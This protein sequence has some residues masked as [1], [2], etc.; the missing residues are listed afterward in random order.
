M[1]NDSGLLNSNIEIVLNKWKSDFE[2][3]YNRPADLCGFD[4]DFYNQAKQM[5][6]QRE[7]EMTAGDYEMNQEINIDIS[8]DEVE[9][10]I[11][12][13]KYKKAV[14]FDGIPNEALKQPEVVRLLYI[15]FNKCFNLFTLPTIWLKAVISPIPKSSS[16]DPNIPLSYTGISLLSCSCKVYSGI[17]NNRIV[18]YFALLELFAD[19]QNGFRKHRSCIDHIF[20][21][22][23]IIRNRIDQGLSTFCCFIDMKKAFDWVDRD[24]LF[25]KLLMYNIDGKIYNSIK[26]LYSHPLSSIKLNNYRTDWF[27][28]ESGVRQGDSLSPT[29]FGIF[30]YNDLAGT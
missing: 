29:L 27:T 24:L 14:G 20:S 23:S 17:I 4:N 5:K 6:H 18:E 21:L 3:L 11:G 2:H 19:E 1:Y 26:S 9:K 12:N 25:Y 7:Q 30:I 13:L 16:K 10:I 22:T 15:F 28:T 8:Y